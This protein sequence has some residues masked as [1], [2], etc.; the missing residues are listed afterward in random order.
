MQPL[1]I[2][3]ALDFAE[4]QDGNNNIGYG[5][6]GATIIVFSGLAVGKLVSDSSTMLIISRS[7]MATMATCCIAALL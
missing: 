7:S 5:L 6:V 3:R 1:L 4:R 2:R